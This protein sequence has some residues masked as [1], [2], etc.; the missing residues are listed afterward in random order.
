MT[1]L[2]AA[3]ATLLVVAV[4]AG[5]S[6]VLGPGQVNQDRI[7]E[8]A[9]YS[10]LWNSPANATIDVGQSHYRAVYRLHNQSTVELHRFYR[11][12]EE[13][14][15][16]AAAVQFRYPNGTVVGH[17][18]LGFDRTRSATVVTLPAREGQLA[19]TAPKNG[20]QLRVQAVV[21]A[22]DSGIVAPRG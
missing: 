6:A 5:C 20:K 4:L 2:R 15:L 17:E 19:L 1:R 21:E 18:A 13:R 14:P 9:D 10:D 3:A 11:L 16:D 22:Y 7:A 12:N 8:N